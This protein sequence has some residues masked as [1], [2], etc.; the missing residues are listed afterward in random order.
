MHSPQDVSNRFRVWCESNPEPAPFQI[1]GYVPDVVL[2]IIGKEGKNGIDIVRVK[3]VIAETSNLTM[4]DWEKTIE[5]YKVRYWSEMPNYSE[6]IIRN[7]LY[8]GRVYQPSLDRDK[9]IFPFSGWWQS[10][11]EVPGLL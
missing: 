8:G 6:A 9:A 11:L 5:E 3:W 1:G 7:F 4:E 2:G 10:P